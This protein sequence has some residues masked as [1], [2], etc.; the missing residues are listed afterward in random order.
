MKRLQTAR[1]RTKFLFVAFIIFLGFIAFFFVQRS[2][3]IEEIRNRIAI[4][5]PNGIESL[6]FV[7]IGGIRQAVLIRGQDVNNPILLVL[8]GGPGYP[9]I[10]VQKGNFLEDYYTVVYFDQRLSGKTYFA[11]DVDAVKETDSM[12]V[13]INDVIELSEYLTARFDREKIALWGGSWGSALGINVAKK[14]PDLFSVFVSI[15]QLANQD[16][17]QRM[18]YAEA[19]RLAKEAG[20]K[21]DVKALE[22][23]APYPGKGTPAKFDDRYYYRLWKMQRIAR[24]YWDVP[25]TL[26]S[27][28]I[29]E[30]FWPQCYSPYYTFREATYFIRHDMAMLTGKGLSEAAARYMYEEYDLESLGLDFDLPII[31]GNGELDWI[32]PPIL[33]ETLFPQMTAPYKSYHIHKGV[34]HGYNYDQFY[35]IMTVEALRFALEDQ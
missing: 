28:A 26:Q 32:A 6:E 21:S 22:Q 27:G 11:N 17:A 31:L 19:L 29:F 5:T 9:E 35:E 10:A 12:E 23:L 3:R 4:H 33:V 15:T 18:A 14:R 7:E 13:R 1:K 16:T 20:N 30:D 24:K 2:I 34:G 8:H 25:I